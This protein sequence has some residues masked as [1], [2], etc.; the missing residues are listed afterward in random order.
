MTPSQII[1]RFTSERQRRTAPMYRR[2]HTPASTEAW[3]ET[4]TVA[5]I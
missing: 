1:K 4:M 3:N 2:Y 5:W